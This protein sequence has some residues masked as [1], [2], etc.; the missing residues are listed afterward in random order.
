MGGQ[1]GEAAKDIGEH[2]LQRQG[3]GQG[4]HAGQSHHAG[5]VNVQTVGDAQPQQQIEPHFGQGVDKTVGR[6]FQMGLFQSGSLQPQY[7]PDDQQPDGQSGRGR[8]GA[9]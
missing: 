9:V 5:Y 2:I 3:N 7:Q 1:Q 4:Q 6:L 8:K